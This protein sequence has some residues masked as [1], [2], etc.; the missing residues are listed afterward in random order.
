[1]I[2]I[3]ELAATMLIEN[4]KTNR[5]GP[6]KGLR[7]GLRGKNPTLKIDSYGE[8]DHL[9]MHDGVIALIVDKQV[10]AKIGDAF[11]DI[12]GDLNDPYLS[13]RRN[14]LSNDE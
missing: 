10:E 7:L 1:M 2:G 13:I 6:E 12:E 3:N 5:V 14:V 9:I 8:N 4:Y 11:I